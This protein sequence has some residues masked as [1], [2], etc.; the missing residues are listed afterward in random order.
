MTPAT[1]ATLPLQGYADR[2][3]PPEIAH[4]PE[5]AAFDYKCEELAKEKQKAEADESRAR[6]ERTRAEAERLKAE[7]TAIRAQAAV[8]SRE[9]R[10]VQALTDPSVDGWLLVD[11][12]L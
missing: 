8:Q 2:A 9:Q 11:D 12:R 4:S 5:C 6:A 7:T 10:A 3:P 1:R